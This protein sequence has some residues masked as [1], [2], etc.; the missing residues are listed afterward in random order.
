VNDV[1]VAVVAGALRRFLVEHREQPRDVRA[2]VPINLRTS[3]RLT[4]LGNDF[5]LVVVSLPL[6]ISDP[7][8]RL[9]EA[10]RRM[11]VLK[12]SPLTIATPDL[13]RSTSVMPRF[14]EQR[15]AAF[16]GKKTSLVL[17]NVPGPREPLRL[18]GIPIER[19]VFW[20]PQAARVCIGI[21]ILSYAGDVTLGV[22]CDSAIIR[23]PQ[24]I[25]DE[26]EREI[27]LLDVEL[28]V[29]T[30]LTAARH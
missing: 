28:R 1:L 13:L 11:D 8:A 19:V 14:I 15:G 26:L 17:T 9:E 18:L 16:F 4:D 2:I 7:V 24:H 10:K 30:V 20:V 25:A 23:E 22:M 6:A 21:S 3:T 5:G 27:D 29:E 12:S